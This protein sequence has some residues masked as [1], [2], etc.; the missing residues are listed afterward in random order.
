MNAANM[1]IE[2]IFSTA[3]LEAVGVYIGAIET[4]VAI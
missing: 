1:K 4:K 2:I 3:V